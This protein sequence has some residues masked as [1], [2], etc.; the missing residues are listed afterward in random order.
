MS[1]CLR[2]RT[3]GVPNG[4]APGPSRRRRVD[5]RRPCPSSARSGQRLRRDGHPKLP[6]TAG[7]LHARTRVQRAWTGEVR[8]AGWDAVVDGPGCWF[9]HRHLA[10]TRPPRAADPATD[11]R[12]DPAPGRPTP[13][14]ADHV[15]RSRTDT[16]RDAGR[17]VSASARW[18]CARARL[19]HSG[20]GWRLRRSVHSGCSDA[21]APRHQRDV[22]RPVP[23]P[24]HASR[25]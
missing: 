14:S 20:G 8:L 3:R 23:P 4:T 2:S 21:A 13:E 11:R 9:S 22:R 17:R 10:R 19:P 24:A 6:G 16:A 12:T 7:R 15:E 25:V 18:P 1:R 5:Q